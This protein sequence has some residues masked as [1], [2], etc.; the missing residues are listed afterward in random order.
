MLNRITKRTVFDRYL[1]EAEEKKLLRHVGQ[2]ADVLAQ[3][4]AAWMTLARQAGLRVGS[5]A[6]LTVGDAKAALRS[7]RL[8]LADDQVKGHRGYEVPVNSVAR[9]ALGKLLQVRAD[10][11][12]KPLP[13]APLIMSRNQRGMSVRSY[14]SR[15]A[16]WVMDCGLPVKASPHWLRH[17][18]ARRIMDRSEARDPQGIV[19]VALGHRSRESTAVYTLPTREEVTDDLELA[20]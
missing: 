14:Q 20:R 6:A 11:G 7:G 8:T 2:Y 17:T 13:D 15:M 3:R 1:T 19:Q 9:K 18:L 4:D 5:L 12:Y 10:M 16:F